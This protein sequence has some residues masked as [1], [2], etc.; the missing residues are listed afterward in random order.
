[1]SNKLVFSGDENEEKDK[2]KLVN[3]RERWECIGE[4]LKG[5]LPVENSTSTSHCQAFVNKLFNNFEQISSFQRMLL[6]LG[7]NKKQNT[8]DEDLRLFRTVFALSEHVISHC[9]MLSND[10]METNN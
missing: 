10:L 8:K 2:E 7:Q 3:T 6:P 9:T 5:C 4:I 1:M